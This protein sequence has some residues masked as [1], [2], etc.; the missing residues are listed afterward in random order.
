MKSP[1]Q[2]FGVVCGM[3]GAA[4]LMWL[5][6]CASETAVEPTRMPVMVLP[7]PAPVAP[8]VSPGEAVSAGLTAAARED[9]AG[10][11]R[12][13]DTLPRDQ[14]AG[15]MREIFTTVARDEV[16]RAARLAEALPAEAGQLQAIEIVARA[17]VEREAGAAVAWALTWPA[18]YIGSRAREKVADELVAREG[19]AGVERL[20]ALPPSAGRD[21]M[22]A[23][24]A[25]GWARRDAEA[26]I[27]WLR[28]LP[29]GEMKA[30][31]ATSAGF[32]LAR[33]QPERAVEVL[34]W[35]PG[36]RNRWA[37]ISSIGQT[38]VAR[39]PTA[40]WQWARQQP[41]GG[42]REA[43]LTGIETGLGGAGTRIA[44]LDAG[45]PGAV[46]MGR[47]GLEPLSPGAARDASVLPPGLE[48]DLALRREFE[49]A[50]LESPTRAADWLQSVPL[51]D[52][53]P[54]MMDDIARRWLTIN[55]EAAKQW[56]DQHIYL[57][58]KKEQLLREA[59]R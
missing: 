42:A 43:A 45:S 55:P 35:I 9:A 28:T 26:A 38:W 51:P 15:A 6:G 25:G 13:V 4:G 17:W 1:R 30:R 33:T 53:R 39:N 29:E 21:Q 24:A 46:G 16:T 18:T 14:R 7:P 12:A 48:R 8:P 31:V 59:G 5:A 54:E 52:R 11:Q 20:G 27:G 37:L 41:A 40:A 56:M 49:R 23:F 34:A 22:L 3:S 47:G 50:L 57:P 19:R 2:I 10:L 36:G 58:E 32:A 44:T